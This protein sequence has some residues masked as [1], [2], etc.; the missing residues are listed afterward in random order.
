MSELLRPVPAP[1]PVTRLYGEVGENFPHHIDPETGRW[2]KC[3]LCAGCKK[4]A[5]CGCLNPAPY[6]QH[7]GTDF[8]CRE[9]T[10][11]VAAADGMVV[12]V[13]AGRDA[14]AHTPG[15]V[16]VQL[17]SALGFDNWWLTYRNVRE[18]CVQ[19]GAHVK[20]GD[21]LGYTG[22]AGTGAPYLHVD[23][24]DLQMQYRPLPVRPSICD[25]CRRE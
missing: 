24:Q 5:P 14:N 12:R 17:V 23:L 7:T 8:A 13:G 9:G 19:P 22:Y 4:P 10:P 20:A 11:V 15:L 25:E 3:Q 18:F 1:F 21:R 16:I 2:I 6:G